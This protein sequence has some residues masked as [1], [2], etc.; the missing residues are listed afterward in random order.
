MARRVT[1]A[2]AAQESGVVRPAARVLAADALVPA[3]NLVEP[4][5]NKF[6][7][8][9]T[10]DEPYHYGSDMKAPPNGELRQGTPVLLVSDDGHHARVIDEHGLYVRVRTDSLRAHP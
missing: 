9:L 6:S 2:E 4:P 7:H 8:V 3:A 1:K 10:R 5:P